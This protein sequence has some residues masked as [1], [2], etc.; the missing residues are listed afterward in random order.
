MK[1]RDDALA[2]LHEFTTTQSLRTHAL[3]VEAAMGWYARHYGLQEDQ[4]LLWRVTGLLHDFDYEQ[5]PDPTPPNGHPYRGSQIL[6][7]RGYPDEMR[8]AIMGHAL[9]TGTPRDTLLSKALFAC[10]ELCGLI[11]AAVYVRPDR[12]ILTLEPSSVLKRMKDKAFARGC[13]RED[14]KLGAHE[15]GIELPQ[16]VAHVLEAMKESGASLGLIPT[17]TVAQS[18]AQ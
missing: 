10:D 13:N 7:E 11:T 14:I 12:S 18:A 5:F 16:H 9:Y 2:L 1:T 17:A 3:A 8:H 6:A 4:Q 15:L